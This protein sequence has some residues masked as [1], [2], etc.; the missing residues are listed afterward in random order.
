MQRDIAINKDECKQQR[1]NTSHRDNNAGR[2]Q[3][4]ILRIR[5]AHSRIQI[6]R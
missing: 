3:N 4:D 5:M 6:D 2:K 1:D